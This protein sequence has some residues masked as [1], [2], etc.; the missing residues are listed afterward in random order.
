[1]TPN[2]NSRWSYPVTR[3]AWRP[4]S[5]EDRHDPGA[6]LDEALVTLGHGMGQ[7]FWHADEQRGDEQEQQIQQVA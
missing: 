2:R 3:I 5:D 4:S 6:F 7:S 1:M